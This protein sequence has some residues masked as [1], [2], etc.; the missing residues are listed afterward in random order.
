MQSVTRALARS[1]C[2]MI[3]S[4]HITT[5]NKGNGWSFNTVQVS[6]PTCSKRDMKPLPHGPHVDVAERPGLLTILFDRNYKLCVHNQ[7][8]RKREKETDRWFI[9]SVHW[10]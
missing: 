10:T 4:D 9:I 8:L 7:K 1:G 6:C 3:V 2:W 5:Q